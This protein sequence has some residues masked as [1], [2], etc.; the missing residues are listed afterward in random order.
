MKKVKVTTTRMIQQLFPFKGKISFYLK[1]NVGNVLTSFIP[2]DAYFFCGK[3]VSLLVPNSLIENT[4]T[5]YQY[6]I[7]SQGHRPGLYLAE[8]IEKG[9][10]IVPEH[11][12]LLSEI[13]IPN[14]AKDL[15]ATQD[16]FAIEGTLETKAEKLITVTDKFKLVPGATVYVKFNHGWATNTEKRTLQVNNG[17]AV[18]LKNTNLVVAANQVVM[19]IYDGAYWQALSF[20]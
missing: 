11:D 18:P 15:L 13:I 12:C 9:I 8:P 6:S 3:A 10:C 19:F 14:V 20:F 7:Y 2:D 4:E 16:F 17:T 1:G 5:Y